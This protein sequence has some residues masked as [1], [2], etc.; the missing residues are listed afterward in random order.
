MSYLGNVRHGLMGTPM[1]TSYGVQA[2]QRPGIPGISAMGGGQPPPGS[3]M[4]DGSP[5]GA[6]GNM[7][8]DQP[9]QGAPGPNSRYGSYGT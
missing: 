5:F 9:G 8:Q 1:P 6:P 3:L 7:W 4:P 2:P